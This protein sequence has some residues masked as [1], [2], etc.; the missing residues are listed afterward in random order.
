MADTQRDAL[1]RRRVREGLTRGR[2]EEMSAQQKAWESAC[3]AWSL[4]DGSDPEKTGAL[5]ERLMYAAIDLICDLEE[6]LDH[7]KLR[8][9]LGF[10]EDCA[11][12]EVMAN[13]RDWMAI[14]DEAVK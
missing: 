2:G 5:G 11:P 4:D 12:D 9:V 1:E 7:P 14:R 6:T 13:Q 3:R 8:Q 10:V